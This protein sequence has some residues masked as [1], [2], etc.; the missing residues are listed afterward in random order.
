[1]S[2]LMLLVHLV[3]HF[4]GELGDTYG[5]SIDDAGVE[6]LDGALEILGNESA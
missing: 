2:D 1:M 5:E 6:S 4:V 3:L